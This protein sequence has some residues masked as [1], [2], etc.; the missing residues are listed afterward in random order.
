MKHE[1]LP[2]LSIVKTVLTLLIMPYADGGGDDG[3][4]LTTGEQSSSVNSR[5]PAHLAGNWANIGGSTAINALAGFNDSLANHCLFE[6][7]KG[8]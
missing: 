5:Q 6:I 2:F 4:G 1:L 3:L 7:A 8:S